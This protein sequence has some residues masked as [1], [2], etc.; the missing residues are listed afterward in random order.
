[1]LLVLIAFAASPARGLSVASQ[2]AWSR[3]MM[4][5]VELDAMVFPASAD[6]GRVLASALATDYQTLKKAD[7][8]LQDADAVRAVANA[9]TLEECASLRAVCD[10][11]M[12]SQ[13][14]VD[15]VD[16]LP[17]FQ[18]NLDFQEDLAAVVGADAVLRL[19][20]LPLLAFP[21]DGSFEFLR[22]GCFVR[23]YTPD[24]RTHMPFHVDGNAF[25][26]NVA[27]SSAED[28]CGGDLIALFGGQCRSVARNL[29]AATVHRGNVLHAVSPLTSGERYALL[30]FF[31]RK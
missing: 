14:N 9:L 6:A 17:D 2:F 15:N 24:S 7:D 28:H 8:A 16:R 10:E 5:A 25:T 19:R 20:R 30:L 4:P 26:A 23:R 18:V 12:E 22:V 29:G 1:M 27:L 31:H 21:E 3:D 13:M 11:Q